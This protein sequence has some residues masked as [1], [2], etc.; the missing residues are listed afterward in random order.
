[1]NLV[2][3]LD[4]PL[5]GNFLATLRNKE[6]RTEEFRMAMEKLGLLLAVEATRDLPT[7]PETVTTPL[8]VEA[9]CPTVKVN[10]IILVPILRAG[11]GF[12]DSFLE[13]LPAAKVAHIGVAR[14]HETFAARTY[15]NTLPDNTGDCDRVFVLDP[16][17]ATGNS[18]V[19]A[20]RLVVE[21]GYRPD[22]ITLVTALSV[23]E[24]IEHVKAEFPE[25]KIVTGVIDPYLNEKAYIVPGLGDAGDRLNLL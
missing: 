6:T 12:V 17:L 11:L 8:E 20:L 2:T 13:V 14:D 18:S 7:A 21:K 5:A 15:V 24:G 16:M 25:L 22:T 1:M 4:H 9:V 23:N 3:V 19:S 10:R